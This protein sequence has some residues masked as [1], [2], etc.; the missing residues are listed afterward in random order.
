MMANKPFFRKLPDG[1]NISAVGF[2]CS[3]LWAS[4]SLSAELAHQLLDV[5]TQ[6]GIN[7][8][9]TGPSY[10]NGEGERRLGK[11]LTLTEVEK[12]IVST[13]VGT[14]FDNHGRQYKDFSMQGMEKSFAK[15]LDR[16]RTPYVDILYLHGPKVHDL[17][18]EVFRFFENEKARGRIKW[19]GVNSFNAKV[20]RACVAS[21]IDAVMLQYSIGDVSAEQLL[22]ELAAASKIII[23]GTS[24]AQSIFSAKTFLPHNKKQ[25]WYLLRALKNNPMF[26]WQGLE[27]ARKIKITNRPGFSAALGFVVGN[28][29]IQSSLFG[30]TSIEH[31]RQNI[32]AARNPL[33]ESQRYLFL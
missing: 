33:P 28:K 3:S 31:M 23:S 8:F 30:T 7:H 14:C 19:S 18:E 22:P 11:F 32:S 25:T 16:L 9:D 26:W 4:D 6:G 2:G 13:K 21:P 24:L 27:L 20:L 15:S 29:H 10:G 12:Y 1:R 5:A 17:N